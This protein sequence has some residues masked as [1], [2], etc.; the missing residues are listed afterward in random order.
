MMHIRLPV[1][2]FAVLVLPAACT[3]SSSSSTAPTASKDA[4]TEKPS[5]AAAPAKA[6]QSMPTWIVYTLPG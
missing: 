5:K 4:G 2:A 6:E 1:L 3:E